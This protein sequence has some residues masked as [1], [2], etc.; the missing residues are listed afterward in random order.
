[1]QV[2]TAQPESTLF[3]TLREREQ[4]GYDPHCSSDMS[5]LRSSLYDLQDKLKTA[6]MPY[7]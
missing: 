1:M 4:S 7:G 3:L 6:W 5:R 2:P